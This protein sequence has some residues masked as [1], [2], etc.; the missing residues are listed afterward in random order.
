MYRDRLL[1]LL[2]RYQ[3]EYPDESTCVERFIEFVSAYPN[4]FERSLSIG[5]VTGSAW[6]VNQA[7][8]HVL[9]TLHKNLNKWL[10]LGGHADG[11]PHV[12]DVAIREAQEESGLSEFA[13]LSENIFDIDIHLIPARK[14]EAAH[15][16]YDVRFALQTVG[17]EEYHISDESHDLAWIEVQKVREFTQEEA[18]LRMVRKWQ[19]LPK[20]A[21]FF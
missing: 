15:Y 4:C 13:V 5:H 18:M 16:H 11:N 2:Y 17:S 19:S 9:L 3:Q 20:G 14:H 8:T 12:L 21:F 7:K 6:L 1:A 10:Q